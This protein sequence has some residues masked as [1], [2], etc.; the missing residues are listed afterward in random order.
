MFGSLSTIFSAFI[1]AASTLVSAAPIQPVELLVFSP[2]LTSPKAGDMWTAGQKYNVTWE[3]DNIPDEKKN[4]TGMILLGY[5]YNNSEN[6][7]IKHPLGVNFLLTDGFYEVTVP[8]NCSL[9]FD[10][11]VVLFGDSGN[12]SPDFTILPSSQT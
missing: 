12:A 6:L 1:L 4:S 2:T 9:R 8:S 5:N 10:Y 11:T 7:D 3:T